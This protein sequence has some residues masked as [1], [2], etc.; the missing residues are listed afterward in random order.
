MKFASGM[1][2]MQEQSVLNDA[3]ASLAA[4]QFASMKVTSSTC[5]HVRDGLLVALNVVSKLLLPFCIFK[6]VS[7]LLE[8]SK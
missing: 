2:T 4:L 3:E 1:L 8:Q 5:I 6:L 7:A